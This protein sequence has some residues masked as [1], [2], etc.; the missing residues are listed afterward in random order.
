MHL[1]VLKSYLGS[2]LALLS[3][4]EP[5]GSIDYRFQALSGKLEKGND[6]VGNNIISWR[7]MAQ[8]CPYDCAHEIR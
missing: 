6:L 1:G 3:E 7:D 2:V 8:R 5:H 4:Q